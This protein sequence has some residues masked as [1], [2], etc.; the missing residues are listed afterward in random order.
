MTTPIHDDVIGVPLEELDVSR[1]EIYQNDTWQ[2]WFERL[3]KEAPVHFVA[4]S[5]NG[6]FWSVTSHQLIKEVDTNNSIFS[7]EKGGISIVDLVTPEGQ[8]QGKN[9]I[10]MD[11]PDHAKQRL[12]VSPSVAPKN[13]AEFEPLIRKNVIDILENLPVGETFNWVQEVSIELTARMLATLFDFPYE[14]RRKLVHWSDIATAVPQVTGDD[15][16]D[17]QERYDE[18]MGCAAAFYNLWM[19]KAGQPPSFDLIS[20]LQN[21]PETARMN[22]DPELFLGNIILL[23][24]GGNDTTRNSISGGVIGLNKYPDQYQKLRDNPGLIPNMVAEIVRWQTP[25]I[26]M[27]RTALEDYELGGKHIKKGDKVVMWYLSGNRDETVF[28]D[29]EKLIIDR[30]NARAHVAFG[31]G[32]HRCMGNRL[33]EMQLRVLWEEIMK[34][35]HQVEVVGD[36]ERLSNNF[37]RG[38]KD[39]PVRLH[40]I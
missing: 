11:E 36:V 26:H 22:E 25:V 37:I 4:D 32:V 18:L 16:I 27:R 29:P 38:I 40:P 14:Q 9:F 2:P 20:M 8:I 23:I 15:S 17:M 28:E 5:A 24:V 3:R 1:P 13:L 35:F 21:N 39:V 10:A 12:A 33:A 7:S 31:F 30:P 34:R 6:P 19:A